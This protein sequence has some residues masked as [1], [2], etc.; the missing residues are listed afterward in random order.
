MRNRQLK[1]V[2]LDVNQEEIDE[3]YDRFDSGMADSTT[4]NAVCLALRKIIRPEYHPQIEYASRHHACRL[5]VGSEKYSLPMPVFWWLHKLTVGGEVLP[6]SFTIV[7]PEEMF[8]GEPLIKG[9][10]ATAIAA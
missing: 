1:L 9:G 6:T 5:K 7:L 8:E 2:R 4:A 3:M 10:L